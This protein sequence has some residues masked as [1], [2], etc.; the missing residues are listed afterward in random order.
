MLVI[1][2][3]H[4]CESWMCNFLQM[5][6]GSSSVSPLGDTLECVMN[7]HLQFEENE[8]ILLLFLGQK[9]PE[10]F[11]KETARKRVSH[12]GG[13]R[14]QSVVIYYIHYTKVS[15]SDQNVSDAILPSKSIHSRKKIGNT[16]LG[17]Q[18]N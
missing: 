15:V 18:I 1:L 9:S 6:P 14:S 4:K 12:D 17:Q 11:V 13:E 7:F 10:S 5:Q 3:Q 2:I 16:L 8:M